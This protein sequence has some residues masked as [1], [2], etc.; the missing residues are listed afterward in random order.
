[1]ETRRPAVVPQG[2]RRRRVIAGVRAIARTRVIRHAGTVAQ[3]PTQASA[4]LDFKNNK[5]NP[6]LSPC[7]TDINILILLQ[8]PNTNQAGLEYTGLDLSS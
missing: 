5:S 4:G 6:T 1:M 3:I 8:C 7:A 2:V